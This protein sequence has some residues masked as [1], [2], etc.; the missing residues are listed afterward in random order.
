VKSKI[1]VL[2]FLF[3]IFTTSLPILF[4]RI[5]TSFTIAKIDAMSNF[6]DVHFT[7]YSSEISINPQEQKLKLTHV[8]ISPTFYA[9]WL[10]VKKIG[11]KVSLLLF[12]H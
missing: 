4:K 12:K 9:Q 11:G 6:Y 1:E 3:S 10:F 8:S 7:L 5:V 2:N